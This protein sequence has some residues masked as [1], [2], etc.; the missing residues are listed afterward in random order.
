MTAVIERVLTATTILP[1][2][3]PLMLGAM[4]VQR[5]EYTA[6]EVQTNAGIFGHSYC[7]AREAP[8]ADIVARLVA[9]HVVSGATIDPI[10]L[11]ERAYR[12]S[13]IVGRVGLVRRA[14]G[15]VDIALWDAAGKTAGRA[16]YDL[17]GTGAAP[18]PTMLV[19]AYPTPSRSVADLVDGVLAD[20]AEGWPLVKISRTPDNAVMRELIAGI[21]SGL[22]DSTELVVDVGFGWADSDAALSDIAQWGD[23][24]LAWLED[25]LLPEDVSGCA[26]LRAHSGL[27]IGVGDEVTDPAVLRALVTG[28]AVDVLRV[29][30]VAI[31]GI[32]PAAPIVKWALETGTEVS[33]HV[34][35]ETSVHLGAGVETFDRSPDGNRYDPSPTLVVGGPVFTSGWATPSADPGLGFELR[36][37]AFD[38]A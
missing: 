19:S 38:F 7:L 13:A 27:R 31:G 17:L 23:P 15:L 21:T 26:R 5:R 28:E 37:G 33:L 4:T 10:S 1:L 2:P 29:D 36:D 35:A 14:I 20:A 25:P 16:V 34:S 32:T 24:Q 18:R 9:P 22:P 8:M 3:E 30:V 6:V 11:W 12:G